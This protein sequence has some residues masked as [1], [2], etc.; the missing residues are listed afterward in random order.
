MAAVTCKMSTTTRCGA[1]AATSSSI[2]KGKALHVVS[3]RAPRR[4]ISTVCRAE[5]SLSFSDI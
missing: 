2:L 4:Q 3:V 5:V 1:R